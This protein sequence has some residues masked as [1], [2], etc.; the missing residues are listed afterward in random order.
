M[1]NHTPGEWKWWTSNSWRRL[2]SELGHGKTADVIYPYVARDNHPNLV[3]SE[4]DMR[5]IAAAPDLLAF[6]KYVRDMDPDNQ[7]PLFANARKAI[8]KAEG[9]P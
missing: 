6:A 5:L 3:V 8:A 2:R 1:R 7:A 4:E 9:N